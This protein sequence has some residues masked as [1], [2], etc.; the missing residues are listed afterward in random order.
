MPGTCQPGF[1]RMVQWRKKDRVSHFGKQLH[2]AESFFIN[3]GEE[4][5]YF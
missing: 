2:A 3:P 5:L 1:F 4:L